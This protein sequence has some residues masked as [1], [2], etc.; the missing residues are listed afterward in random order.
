MTKPPFSIIFVVLVAYHL[1]FPLP[2]EAFPN[3]LS[4]RAVSYACFMKGII[5][6]ARGE[7]KEAEESF[8][9]A[10]DVNPGQVEIMKELA[11]VAAREHDLDK[12][13][14]WAKKVLKYDPQD[15]DTTVLLS[16]I[17]AKE[18]RIKESIDLLKEV[19]Q[20]DPGNKKALFNL[21][22][23]YIETKNYAK[24]INVLERSLKKES[25]H[26]FIIHYYLGLL[27]LDS[28]KYSQA[29]KH[30]RK[31]IE[32]NPDMVG[33]FHDLAQL[34]REKGDNKEAIR[35][36]SKYLEKRPLDFKTRSEFIR[37]LMDSGKRELA[38]G[39][40]DELVEQGGD[41]PII[42][43]RAVSYYIDLGDYKKALSIIK[44]L[45]GSFPESPQ[46]FFYSGI[47]Y[48]GIGDT[49]SAI[50]AYKE[51]GTKEPV[52][53]LSRIR[54]ARILREK[55]RLKE[56]L[57][58]LKEAA[59]NTTLY[60]EAQLKDAFLEMAMLLDEMGKREEAVK[61]AQ[62]ILK[63]YPKYPPA[64]NFIGYTYAEM[65]KNLDEAEK[66]IKLALKGQPDDGYIL[67]SL[68]WVYFK[69]G[70]IHDAIRVLQR[71]IK[72]VPK[73]PIISEHI[74]DAYFKNGD[75]EKAQRMYKKAMRL[76][77]KDEDK[78]RLARKIQKANEKHRER[79][80]M[81]F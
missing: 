31:T 68:G 72:L 2:I 51:V 4:N 80:F 36:Y 59:S 74:G 63:N 52:Y 46:L 16:R 34:Y 8:K 19:L 10:L 38:I 54:I 28:K 25:R 58:T 43:L 76:T 50:R 70:K 57:S 13:R 21:W 77:E 78:K 65:G 56:A 40:V 53:L 18:K 48:E 69:K 67:D 15:I 30:L 41:D 6:K 23:I 32:L 12:A 55:G 11:Q 62:K 47:A 73:D 60:Q 66:M 24:A 35:A 37:F 79:L 42:G 22:S 14:Y 81:P 75:Y 1:C 17:Y 26:S 71:A 49:D 9:A 44:R 27:Y 39:Q 64:L 33:V 20:R 7:Y 5:E 3:N 61:T 29:E 45:Q